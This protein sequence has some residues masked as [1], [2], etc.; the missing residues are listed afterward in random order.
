VP[1]LAFF[2]DPHVDRVLGVVME[3]AGEVYALRE[4]LDTVER[5]LT[6]RGVLVDE[7]LE[8]YQLSPE[9]RAAR[10]AEREAFVSRLLAPMTYEA[11]SPAPPYQPA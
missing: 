10:L 1:D 4:R 8:H 9:D 2:P 6:E 11:D 5:L 3:L 7:E